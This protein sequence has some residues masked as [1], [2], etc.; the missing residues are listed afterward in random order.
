MK[1]VTHYIMN[2][3][4]NKY[5][6]YTCCSQ[7][8]DNLEKISISIRTYLYILI[9]LQVASNKSLDFSRIFKENFENVINRPVNT[10]EGIQS[11][12]N[13]LKYTSPDVNY[14][15]AIIS[16]KIKRIGIDIVYCV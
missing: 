11:Y 6:N 7:I 2:S 13:V 14:H 16:N 10:E 3:V 1:K 4:K 8:K 12:H 9:T 15:V 5:C